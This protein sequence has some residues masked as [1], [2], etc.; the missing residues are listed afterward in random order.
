MQKLLR[1]FSAFVAI[2]CLAVPTASP[3]CLI[4]DSE[5]WLNDTVAKCFSEKF[6][7]YYSELQNTGKPVVTVDLS[8]CGQDGARGGLASMPG[9]PSE[10]P[11]TLYLLDRSSLECL[12]QIIRNDSLGFNPTRLVTLSDSCP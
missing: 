7:L 8:S 4:C 10:L 5:I 1:A 11:A 3:M 6:P 9:V 2:T 12:D